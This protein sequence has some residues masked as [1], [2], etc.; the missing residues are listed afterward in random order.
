M[1]EELDLLENYIF[2]Q[3]KRFKDNLHI[4]INVDENSKLNMCVPPLTLQLL[5]ENAIKHNAISIETPLVISITDQNNRL[6][7]TNNINLKNNIE[8]STGFGLQ[9]IVSMYELLTNEKVEVL[10]LPDN[11]TVVIP[12]LSMKN[13][14]INS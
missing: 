10:N 11:F 1:A 4:I 7:I 12:L 9:K 8:S 6:K 5:A 3:K 2:I 13:E 14:Y